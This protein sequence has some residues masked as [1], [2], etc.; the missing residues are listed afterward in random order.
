MRYLVMVSH[1]TFAPGLHSVLNMLAGERPNILSTSLEDG[2]SADTFVQ[3]LS[4]LIAPITPEDEVVL[5]GDIIGGSPLTNALN[6]LQERGLLAHSIAVGGMNLPAAM[7]ASMGLDTMG[8][9]DLKNMM[10][11]EGKNGLSELAIALDDA[12]DEDEI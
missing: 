11:M 5:M 3:N 9:E 1:G 6:L 12:D 2:M 10:V 7:T 8:L 4:E